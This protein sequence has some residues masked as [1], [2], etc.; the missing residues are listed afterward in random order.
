MNKT[1]HTSLLTILIP[2]TLLLTAC[3]MADLQLYGRAVRGSGNVIE[4]TR[5]VNGVS[6][7]NLATIGH[8]II[9][10]G[11]TES[12]RIEA[13]DNL[14]EYLETEVFNGEL[15]IQTQ[16][17]L[18][19]RT[20]QP[21][22]YYLTVTD[23]D[24]ISIFSS[25]D[26]QAPHL[27]AERFSITVASSGNLKMGDLKADALDVQIFSSG[28]VTV[29]ALN[30][31]TLEINISS[32]GNLHIAGGEVKTQN[33]TINSSGKYTAQDLASEEAQV[34]INSSGSATIRVRNHLNAQL[35]SS[36]DL[37]YFGNPA[38]DAMTNSS[39]DVIQMGK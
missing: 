28:D 13:E 7:V 12:L 37:R 2:A 34:R 30:A 5:A 15:R 19:M 22:N 1:R 35:K 11:D 29:G 18:N 8:L 17:N 36:G 27:Q 14:L 23:L 32:S 25:G 3:K 24:R 38:V 33:I 31:N 39:G 26:I 21:V 16:S 6:G 4:E 20:T 9:E 10:V